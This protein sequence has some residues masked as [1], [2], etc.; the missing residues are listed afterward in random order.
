[1]K[2]SILTTVAVAATMIAFPATKTVDFTYNP[3]NLPARGYGF[4]K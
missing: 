4:D 3:D 1:M 2:R